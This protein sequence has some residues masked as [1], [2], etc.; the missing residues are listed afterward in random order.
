M[1]S[2]CW[3]LREKNIYN[4]FKENI[5]RHY[6]VEELFPKLGSYLKN[7]NKKKV[8]NIGVE[9][10]NK[11]DKEFFLNDNLYFC[12]LDKEKKNLPKSWEKIYEI[13]LCNEI[14]NE[15]EQFDVIVD[16]GVIGWPGI[17]ENLSTK[18]IDIYFQNIKKILYYNGF[19]FLKIDYKLEHTFKKNKIVLEYV[20]K[21]FM[22][23]DELDIKYK[24]LIQDTSKQIYYDTYVFKL[25]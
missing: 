16:Y 17:N 23:T 4:F 25:I 10:F 24:R 22:E 3:T 9:Y 5:D 20:N 2:H 8:L 11:Y 18:E 1:N 21:Y 19:Y 12:G 13:N 6:V 15:I 14:K 7:S